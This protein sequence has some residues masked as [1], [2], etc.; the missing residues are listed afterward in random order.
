MDWRF[1]WWV[2]NWR[3]KK[4]QIIIENIKNVDKKKIFIFKTRR[5]LNKWYKSQFKR[6]I[7]I[8]LI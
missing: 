6:K 2:V 8:N 4:R 5:Q 7:N 3:K 1:F